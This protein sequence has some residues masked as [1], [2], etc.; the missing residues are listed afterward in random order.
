M[1]FITPIKLLR[2]AIYNK[3]PTPANL[4]EG[5]PA[6]NQNANQ[7]GLF[8][9]NSDDKLTK[10]GPTFVGLVAPNS[11]TGDPSGPGTGEAD[12]CI[13]EEWLDTDNADGPLLKIW[14]GMGWVPCSPSPTYA[15]VLISLTQPSTANPEGTLWWSPTPGAGMKV[16]FDGS[17]NSIN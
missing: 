3:R 11:A 14:D 15:K 13:G 6:F 4:L 17:W 5:Q 7:P 10:I 12:L 1:S 16:L 9:R 8:L 2:S